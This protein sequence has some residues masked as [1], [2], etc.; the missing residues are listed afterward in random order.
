[1]EFAEGVDLRRMVQQAGPLRVEEACD[2]V[3]QA[4]RGLQHAH[5]RGLVHRDIKPSNLPG[6]RHAPGGVVRSEWRRRGAVGGANR[7]LPRAAQP[8]ALSG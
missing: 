3:A 5:E 4:A 8:N 1:M 2:Y 7:P 6:L